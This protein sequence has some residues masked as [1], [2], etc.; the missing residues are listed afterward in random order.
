MWRIVLLLCS[1]GWSAP[2]FAWRQTQTCLLDDPPAPTATPY[3]IGN[4]MPRGLAWPTPTVHFAV[5]EAGSDDFPR[6]TDEFP[7]ALLE[8]ILASFNA[9]NKPDCSPFSFVYD[10]LTPVN[11]FNREDR[12]NV[13]AF[14]DDQWPYGSMAVAI[15]SVTAT[16]DGVITNADMELNGFE[17]EFAIVTTNRTAW[18]VRNT[19]THEAGHMLGLDHDA[20]PDSTMEFEAQRGETKKRNLLEDDIEGLCA[21]YPPIEEPDPVEPS[22]DGCCRTTTGPASSPLLAALFGLLVVVRRRR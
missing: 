4:E 10:G 22:D 21:V 15:T 7:P 8:E 16:A 1:I 20:V 3:C 19:I 2:A 13:V 17:H 6:T 14:R 9:W 5:S 11:S 12:I 18:D